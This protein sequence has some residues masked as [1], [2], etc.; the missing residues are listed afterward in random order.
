[1]K[2]FIRTLLTLSILTLLAGQA[3]AY[4]DV[5]YD[6]LKKAAEA[7]DPE[8]QNKIG[9]LFAQGIGFP[10]D[11]AKAFHWYKKAADAKFP[12]AMW[13][14]AFMYVRGEGGVKEDLPTAFGLFKGAAEQGFADAQFDLAYMYLQGL[15]TKLDREEGVAWLKK[16]ADQGHP[17]A[18]KLLKQIEDAEK[19][20]QPTPPPATK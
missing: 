9:V 12:P 11:K 17:E 3:W 5:P 13:N 14:L 7:G 8:S 18:K 6:Q 15:G 1:V 19:G 16:A 10:Q 2:S 20:S 4:L